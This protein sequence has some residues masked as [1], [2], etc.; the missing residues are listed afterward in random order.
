MSMDR[1][2]I[3]YIFTDQQCAFA[4][5][6]A[7]NG[8]VHTPKLDALAS[9]GVRFERAYCAQ[10]VCV[11]SR[12]A[13]HTGNWPHENG[14]YINRF[15]HDEQLAEA[16]RSGRQAFFP[17][18]LRAA[19]Y[20][21]GHLGK[22]HI[23]L[24]TAAAD[25][26]GYDVVRC[27][28]DPDVAPALEQFIAESSGPWLAVASLT[29]P[30][31]ICHW[32]KRQDGRLDNGTIPPP[33]PPEECPP[34]PENFEVPEDEPEVVRRF[35]E[36]RG[37]HYVA[38]SFTPEQWRQ[39][40]WAYWRITELV[41]AEIG[42]ILD[43][44]DRGGL[45]DET[46]ILFAADHGDGA[47][48][49]RWCQKQAL[50]EEPSRVPFIVCPPGGISAP[51]VDDTHLVQAGLDL[52]P[53]LCDYAGVEAPAH[54]RGRS[55]RPLVDGELSTDWR[56]AVFVE[57]EFNPG[58]RSYGFRGRMVR[59]DRWKLVVYSEGARREQLF[60]LHADP[61]EM[62]NCV[63]D[64]ACAAIAQ[65]LGRRLRDWMAETGDML[66]SSAGS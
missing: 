19:D 4:M 7:G 16:S 20:C 40:L 49:H 31:D 44:L 63:A 9:R 45:R 35:Q 48:A 23:P 54:L 27:L 61:G 6:C 42:R 11:P 1:P 14:V 32:P 34:L 12:A 21:C 10:P 43:V 17:R 57:S 58:G 18:T 37:E 52:Y 56:K 13:M 36:L 55:V 64:P 62:D 28:R 38:P 3:L 25:A 26:H 29:N 30:H 24:E 39:Y 33:P 65:R 51:R 41:D 2:N 15:E 47:A 8:H 60:D 66:M 53:T 50:Y 59:E 46:L 22:L 5:S